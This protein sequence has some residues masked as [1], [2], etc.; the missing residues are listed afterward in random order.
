MVCFSRSD[1]GFG[2]VGNCGIDSRVE[3]EQWLP[4]LDDGAFLE[5]A[6]VYDAIYTCPNFDFPRAGS[7]T[8]VFLFDCDVASHYYFVGDG[9][10]RKP[11]LLT[12]RVG[13]AGDQEQDEDGTAR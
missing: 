5:E 6:F 11:T 1:S 9:R 10:W 7:L 4:G 13:P 2:L 8:D 12:L 3:P